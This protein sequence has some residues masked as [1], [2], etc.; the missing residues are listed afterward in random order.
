MDAS[1][2]PTRSN[3]ENIAAAIDDGDGHGRYRGNADRQQQERD[4]KDRADR[5]E[6]LPD[7]MRDGDGDDLRLVVDHA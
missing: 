4:E 6:E 2:S 7:E 5:D 1:L 3:Q